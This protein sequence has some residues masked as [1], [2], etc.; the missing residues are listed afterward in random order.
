M[1]IGAVQVGHAMRPCMGRFAGAFLNPQCAQRGAFSAVCFPH[2]THSRVMGSACQCLRD[3]GVQLLWL[4]G[5][6]AKAS[7]I[8]E[9]ELH[10]VEAGYVPQPTVGDPA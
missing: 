8:R 2:A 9:L 5:A 4:V 7:A 1:S 6:D 10:R 3:G